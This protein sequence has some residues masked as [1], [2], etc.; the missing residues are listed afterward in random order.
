[1][2]NAANA[3]RNN[4]IQYHPAGALGFGGPNSN[5]AA[6]YFGVAGGFNPTPPLLA[7]GWN[8]EIRFP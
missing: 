7:Y 5:S 6:H 2:I 1:M 4:T 8:S 3:F